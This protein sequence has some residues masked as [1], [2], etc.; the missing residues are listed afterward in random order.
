V[1]IF[2]FFSSSTAHALF[3]TGTALEKGKFE[4]DVAI[5]PFKSITYGQNFAF[6]HYGLG[7]GF[8][9]HGYLSKHGVIYDWK[10]ST[11]ETYI[12]LLKQWASFE[13]VDL[14]TVIGIRKVLRPL[15]DPS[16]IG[17]GFL[18]TFKIKPSFRIAGHLQYIGNIDMQDNKY[19]VTPYNLG[20]TSEV[21]LYFMLT[22]HLEFASG[23][24]TNS[25][26][27]TRPIYT[28]NYYF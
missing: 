6:L 15:S 10:D 21:G 14:A 5:N 8:E 9:I 11:Y 25:K 27:I 20:Y 16:L 22:E 28:F 23:F 12:G 2:F 13:C 26:G 3:D 7:K 19:E 1:L 18:Y 17:P 4:I 24:F